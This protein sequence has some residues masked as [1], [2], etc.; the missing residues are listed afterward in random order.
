MKKFLALSI[1]ILLPGLA[2]AATLSVSPSSK[3]VNA[4]ETFTVT[5]NLDTQ[6]TAI[7]GVDLR[8]LNFNPTLLQVV[9]SN[10]SA[11]GVQITPGT[12]MPATVSNNVNNSLGRIAFSQVTTGGSKY[13][14][15]GVL[16]TISFKALYG[17]T[18][19]LTFDYVSNRTTDSN[20]AA[21]GTDVLNSVVNGSYTI[22]GASAPVGSVPPGGAYTGSITGSP[23]PCVSGTVL[24]AL[25]NFT[26]ALS[27]G[28]RGANV[29]TL[30]GLLV[31][32]GYLASDSVTGF[33]GPLTQAAVAKYNLAVASK[34][35]TS[36]PTTS[37]GITSTT[38]TRSLTLG[39]TGTDVKA[40][41]IFLNSKGYTVSISGIGS[42]GQESTYFGPA[43]Q[44]ALIRFQIA[45]KITP[46]VGF[47]GPVTRGYVK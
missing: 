37:S 42:K 22:S 9:D 13:T 45:N 28:S 29:S 24:A 43:T 7:D 17:G 47:F 5:V 19:A 1:L 4:G 11:S 18:A 36:C 25:P 20:V 6:N 46:A 14:G 30:Q 41:Q 35:T 40:L 31:S 34:T 12:L 33:Y 38:F 10:V 16:A 3:S 32:K 2:S 8:Y 44:K 26:P 27:Y 39:S 23:T 15:S 21:L